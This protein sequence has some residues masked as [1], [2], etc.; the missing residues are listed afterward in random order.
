MIDMMNNRMMTRPQ[1]MGGMASAVPTGMPGARRKQISADEAATAALMNAS[2]LS[3]SDASLPAPPQGASPMPRPM[4]RPMPPQ[5]MPQGMPAQGAPRLMPAQG[6]GSVRGI[7]PPQG[8]VPMSRPMMGGGPQMPPQ[9]M[10]M[11]GGQPQIDPETLGVLIQQMQQR[12]G[13]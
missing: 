5:G 6:Q 3:G 8:M 13:R 2:N 1:P 10:Q 4:P 7:A 9:D 12:R 11:P